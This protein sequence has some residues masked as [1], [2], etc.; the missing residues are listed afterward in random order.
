[1]LI[2][3]RSARMAALAL[4][5][6]APFALAAP[7]FADGDDA[8]VDATV[9]AGNVNVTSTKGLSRTTV[10]MCDGSLVVSDDWAQDQLS[11]DVPVVGTVR[12]VFQHSGANTTVAAEELL[13][14]LAGADAVNGTRTGDIAYPL[15]A[16]GDPADPCAPVTIPDPTDET[17]DPTDETPDPTTETPNPTT[18]TPNPTTETNTTPAPNTTV[19]SVNVE[20]AQTPTEIPTLVLGETL[21]AGGELPRTGGGDVQPLMLVALSLVGTGMALRLGSRRIR[22][23]S[24][25][26]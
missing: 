22:S 20:R 11:G 25:P 9:S 3:S 26:G 13:T 5:A 16:D 15:S 7:A 12:A 4:A 6:T 19:E 17:P 8:V 2:R 10:V 18:E 21:T 24:S 1:M 23:A 14:L